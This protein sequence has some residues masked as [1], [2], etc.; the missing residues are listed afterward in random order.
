MPKNLIFFST[1]TNGSYLANIYTK[2]L[3]LSDY[4]DQVLVLFLFAKGLNRRQNVE[5]FDRAMPLNC[6][7]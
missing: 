2:S 1:A 3:T 4:F 5:L 6:V 7:L